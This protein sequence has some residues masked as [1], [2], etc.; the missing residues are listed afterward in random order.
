MDE[1]ISETPVFALIG[2]TATGK[3]DIAVEAVQSFPF[4]IISVD[5]AL[6]YR[7]MDIGTAKPSAEVLAVA[8]HHLINIIEPE[9]TYSCAQFCSDV[10]SLCRDIFARGKIPFLV[11]GTMLYFNGLINGLS[12]L[13]ESNKASR[14]ELEARAAEKGWTYMHDYLKDIDAESAERIHPNDPQRIIRAIEVYEQ[15]GMSLSH[16]WRENPPKTFPYKLLK[17]VL[18]PKD[19]DAYREI[20]AQRFQ[21]MLQDGLVGEVKTLM[22]R[23]ELTAEHASMRSVGYRQVWAYLQGRLDEEEMISK[24]IHATRQL[25]KRQLTWLRKLQNDYKF[26]AYEAETTQ[27]LLKLLETHLN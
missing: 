10:E 21:A 12:K 7:H 22:N 15:T 1:K 13:P 16:W 27:N 20:I 18:W 11:G 5:S 26:V 17:I 3:T 19:R 23:G 8:P 6:I 2:P 4:E 25:G 9:E 24:A 14:F